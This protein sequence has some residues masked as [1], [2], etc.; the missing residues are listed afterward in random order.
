[1]YQLNEHEAFEAMTRFLNAF[2][3]RINYDSDGALELIL[4]DIEMQSDG[5]PFDGAAWSDWLKAIAEVKEAAGS[6][7][8]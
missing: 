8:K 5:M 4:A 1:M 7:D 6:T 3:A 2:W